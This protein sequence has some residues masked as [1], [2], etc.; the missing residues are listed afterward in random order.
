MA[1]RA[2]QGGPGRFGRQCPTR[3]DGAADRCASAGR[4]SER[5]SGAAG[6]TLVWGGGGAVRR[7]RPGQA[8]RASVCGPGTAGSRVG[9]RNVS[10]GAW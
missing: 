10:A 5:R 2:A 9:T 4:C 8:R 7:A 1:F 3:E 6:T